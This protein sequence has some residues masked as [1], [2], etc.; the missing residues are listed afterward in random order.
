MANALTRQ[1]IDFSEASGSGEADWGDDDPRWYDMVWSERSR[2]YMT[3]IGLRGELEEE[4][5]RRRLAEGTGSRLDT[6]IHLTG[7]PVRMAASIPEIPASLARSAEYISG[8]GG[9]GRLPDETQAEYEARLATVPD[10]ATRAVEAATNLSMFGGKGAPVTTNRLVIAGKAV[11]REPVLPEAARLA[12]DR[13]FA[14]AA[15]GAAAADLAKG[16]LPADYSGAAMT[17]AQMDD[18]LVGMGYD[19]RQLTLNQKSWLIQR[20]RVGAKPAAAAETPAIGGGEER[21]ALPRPA[22]GGGLGSEGGGGGGEPRI[23]QASAEAD[24]AAAGEPPLEGLPRKPIEL[25]DGSVHVPGPSAVAR[26]AAA[27]YM[28]EAGIPYNPTNKYKKVDKEKAAKTAQAFEDMPHAPDDPA[29]QSAYDALINE[30]MAQWEAVKRTGLKIEFNPPGTNPYKSNPRMAMQ[31]IRENNH[32]WVFPTSEGF[33]T[34]AE[35]AAAMRDNPMLRPTSEVISGQP[36]VANDIFRIVHDYFGHYKEG[37]GFRAEGEHNAFRIHRDMFTPPA[38]RALASETRGQNSW[39]NYGPHGEK[40]RH[41]SGD[42]TQYAPQKIGLMPEWTLYAGG[43]GGRLAA[44]LMSAREPGNRLGFVPDLRVRVRNPG[45][46]PDKPLITQATTNKNAQAQLDNID[47]ILAGFPRA[48][49]TPKDWSQMM[50]HAFA[51][52]EVPIPPYAFIRDINGDGAARK[53]ASLSPGQIA[54]ADHG[55]AEAARMRQ[56]YEAGRLSPVTT[57]KLFMWSF[58]SRGVSPYTQESLFIDAFSGANEWIQ[59]AARGEFT[60]DDIP[61]YKEW[62]ASVAP[63]DTGLPGSGALHNLNA[64]GTH[65]LLKMGRLGADGIS[66]LQRLHDML[67]N[68][69]MTGPQIRREFMKFGEGV[70]IDNKVVSFTLLVAGKKDVMV[71]DRVQTRQLWD[72]GR[73]ADR[74]I[75]DGQKVNK[76]VVTGTALS[77]LTYGARGLLVYE[78]IERTLGAKIGDI[79]EAAG[80]RRED[81]SIGRFHWESWVAHSQQEASHGTLGAI[82][83]DALGRRNVPAISTVSAKEGE[84]G[85]FA[86]G[87]RYARDENGAPYFSYT[88]PTGNTYEFSVPAWRQFLADV[89]KRKARVVPK[90]FKVTESGNAPW[91]EQSGVDPQALDRLA[92]SRSDR[93]AASPGAGAVRGAEQGQVAGG[94]A[95]GAGD[96][97]SDPVVAPPGVRLTPVDHNPFA[98]EPK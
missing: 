18:I 9:P 95:G 69:E 86:Y 34:G 64:F 94:P 97:R 26:K 25:A 58:L 55:F 6:V 17:V 1:N 33:G 50:A 51:S 82:M 48:T 19:P 57:G 83:E 56:A 78:A 23:R 30:T 81:A 24:L 10:E 60:K 12:A 38:Q 36:V 74:N 72:D 13:P 63:K 90:G 98:G 67:A 43:R 89:K 20:E 44:G 84:Y 49:E 73:F 80:R 77:N 35:A 32:L 39:V 61:A 66:N 92:S 2:R 70:G 5:R 52:D 79:Y 37:V 28:A 47:L 85:A 46:L 22:G 8:H 93:G 68:P 31:D 75:Y 21:A 65:F 16:S 40:N 71:I 3:R 7:L 54:D 14:K 42:D 45:V 11:G 15:T 62:A 88:V 96:W 27:D 41:A 91:Y 4:A 87:A 53:I 59:K 76:K 29:V